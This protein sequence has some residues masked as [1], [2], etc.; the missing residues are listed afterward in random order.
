MDGGAQ[1]ILLLGGAGVVGAHLAEALMAQNKTICV[2]DNLFASSTVSG[3]RREVNDLA[4]DRLRARTAEFIEASVSD[5]KAIADVLKRFQPDVVYF[6]A[7]LLASESRTDPMLA[8]HTQ[9]DGLRHALELSVE[10]GV[11]RFVYA[12]SS[13]VYGDVERDP[14]DELHPRRPVDPYGRTKLIGEE[15]IEVVASA[16]G[17]EFAIL[18]PAAIYGVGDARPRFVSYAI[19]QAIRNEPI[20]VYDPEFISDFTYAEDAAQ[21]FLLAGLHPAAANEVFNITYGEAR[22]NKEFAEALVSVFPNAKITIT[23]EEEEPGARWPDRAALAIVK[24]QS[25]LGYEPTYRLE[26]GIRRYVA[27]Y[28]ELVEGRASE[29]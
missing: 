11:G 27:R 19:D 26:D 9:V 28:E 5:R 14:V 25:I 24:A 13:F 7:A 10:A 29:W 6:L 15:L 3:S 16:G 8:V 1:R 22:T 12:S 20:T 23:A 17:L 2:V 18:R 21:G 4:V